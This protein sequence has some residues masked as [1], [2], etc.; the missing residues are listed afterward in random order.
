MYLLES[1]LLTP[2]PIYFSNI[3]INQFFLIYREVI[4]SHIRLHA[5]SYFADSTKSIAAVAE[6]RN[7]TSMCKY[8]Q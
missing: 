7:L 6:S 4:K 8:K 2:A 3:G 1:F 5:V